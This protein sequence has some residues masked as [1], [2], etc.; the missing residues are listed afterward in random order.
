VPHAGLFRSTAHAIARQQL[1]KHTNLPAF[2]AAA[3]H[4][5]AL[6]HGLLPRQG[7]RSGS[8][9]TCRRNPLFFRPC[10][11]PGHIGRAI[12]GFGLPKEKKQE[13]TKRCHALH[14]CLSAFVP[15]RIRHRLQPRARVSAAAFSPQPTEGFNSA[16]LVPFNLFCYLTILII[17]HLLHAFSVVLFRSI[18]TTHPFNLPQSNRSCFFASTALSF[19][20]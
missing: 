9:F 11:L 1:S 14:Q 13:Y 7:N 19:G 15:R 17:N 20:Q 16:S 4:N 12:H 5:P 2:T 18:V 10:H 3:L 8:P 6:R